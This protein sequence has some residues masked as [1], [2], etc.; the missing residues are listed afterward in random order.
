[1]IKRPASVGGLLFP[2]SLLQPRGQGPLGLAAASSGSRP[3]L[4]HPRGVV[5][6]TGAR[7]ASISPLHA[8]E[9][10]TVPRSKK[11]EGPKPCQGHFPGAVLGLGSRDGR[12]VRPASFCEFPAP[13]GS[14]W[15][16]ARAEYFRLLR[17]FRNPQACHFRVPFPG[18][19]Q[20]RNRPAGF[21][22]GG[23]SRRSGCSAS[24]CSGGRVQEGL[25]RFEG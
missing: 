18:G 22:P 16:R 24:S 23:A 21:H 20:A 13:R 14:G 6:G 5:G 8:A 25:R 2:S 10:C 1:M 17:Y 3:P 12:F 9:G 19:F 7:S 15:T 4:P 11:A